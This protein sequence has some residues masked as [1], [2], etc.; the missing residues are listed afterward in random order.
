MA[1]FDLILQ[2]SGSLHPDG[3]PDQFISEHTG[4][5]RCTRDDGRVR[6]VGKVK[7]YRIHADLAR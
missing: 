4:V 2:T 3:E 7:A 5:I 6:N 1:F